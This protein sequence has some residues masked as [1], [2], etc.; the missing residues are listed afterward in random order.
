[1]S[2]IIWLMQESI[3]RMVLCNIQSSNTV[4][5]LETNWFNIRFSVF[6]WYM[7]NVVMNLAKPSDG[8]FGWLV[9]M[10]MTK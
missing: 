2:E 1:M 10:V 3:N 9:T 4:L 8:F 6:H 5:T 7:G